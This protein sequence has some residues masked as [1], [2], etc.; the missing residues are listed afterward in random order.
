M[1]MATQKSEKMTVS[2]PLDQR[3]IFFPFFFFTNIVTYFVRFSM[4]AIDV[5][6]A[7]SRYFIPSF[8]QASLEE[9]LEKALKNAKSYNEWLE[10]ARQY[11]QYLLFI[12]VWFL[13][14]LFDVLD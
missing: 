10:Y 8:L 5:L 9:N 12:F 6:S 11:D 3:I 1:I 4:S 7:I 13:S 14:C 2:P